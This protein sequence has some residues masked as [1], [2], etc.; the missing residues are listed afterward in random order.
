MNYRV[1]LGLAL[2]TALPACLVQ[3]ADTG[4]GPVAV[5]SGTLVLD[6]TVAGTKDPDQCDES[7]SRTLDV[8]VT[9]ND[10][11]SAGEFQESCRAFA[12]SI[13]LPPGTYSAD[14]VLLDS[15][16]ADRTTA[17]HVHTFDILGA[18]ELSVPIDFPAGSFYSP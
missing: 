14:A 10:G 17:V 18:D 5:D 11:A 7:D 9:R 16:G 8:R 3:T 1:L 13:D 12:T 15:S 2:S 4:P 6:W